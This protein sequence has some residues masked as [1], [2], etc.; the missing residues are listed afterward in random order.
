VVKFA[1]TRIDA[2]SNETIREPKARPARH[3]PDEVAAK[4]RVIETFVACFKE[5]K[6]VEPRSIHQA[7][8]A[9]AFDLARR[10]GVEEACSIVRRAFEND[11]VVHQNATLRYIAS[12]ADTFRGAA[13]PKKA[14][15]RLEPQRAVGDE[16]WL[17]EHLT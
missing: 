7:D 9:K 14:P 1:L 3:S 13:A 4:G 15:A 16:P 8:H 6:H 12:K 11:F 10:F 17:R 2:P 5:K